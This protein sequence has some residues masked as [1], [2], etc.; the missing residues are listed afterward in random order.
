MPARPEP[1]AGHFASNALPN[2][3]AAR[4]AAANTRRNTI[5]KAMTAAAPASIGSCVASRSRTATRTARD[6]AA[7]HAD[8]ARHGREAVH[9]PAEGG[10]ICRPVERGDGV[11]VVVLARDEVRLEPGDDLVVRV[12]EP[13]HALQVAQVF[14]R[15]GGDSTQ[16]GEADEQV[17]PEDERRDHQERLA[18]A[19]RG[20][21]QAEHEERRREHRQEHATACEGLVVDKRS[22][23][24]E[25]P[26][27]CRE[28]LER[29][30]IVD[31]GA[32]RAVCRVGLERG[33]R[34]SLRGR[35]GEEALLHRS[36][37]DRWLGWIDHPPETAGMTCTVAPSGT[38]VESMA[39]SPATKMLMWVR[40]AGPASSSRFRIPG[41]RASR[42]AITSATV[43][44]SC[45]DAA[46]RA[47]E[48]RDEGAR[49][50]DVGHDG[51]LTSAASTDQIDGRLSAI[52]DQLLPSSRLP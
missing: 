38:G 43:A 17:E 26:V 9:D 30:G 3:I 18:E 46:G 32:L 50:V 40:I 1:G 23:G 41:T 16:R 35:A 51:Q 39:R 27:L 19:G 2:L 28:D 29:P 47:R 42:S 36:L 10:G 8:H 24:Q 45:L 33:D 15:C 52:S 25:A 44:P 20:R 13:V 12:A 7:D 4:Y 48:E 5:T 31:G 37:L 22:S 6:G 11:E 21:D 34:A 14:V 49:Q